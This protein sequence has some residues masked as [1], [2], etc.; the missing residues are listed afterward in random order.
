[1]KTPEFCAWDGYKIIFAFT[2]LNVSGDYE[3]TVALP[4]GDGR[5]RVHRSRLPVGLAIR[6]A[7]HLVAKYRVEM[8]AGL[9]NG[10]PFIVN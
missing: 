3:A 4:T 9:L 1:M 2:P 7:F 5:A 8:P 6:Y 10:A